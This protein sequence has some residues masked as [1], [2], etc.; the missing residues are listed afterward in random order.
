MLGYGS[1]SV[2]YEFQILWRWR[3][4]GLFRHV[5]ITCCSLIRIM[6]EFQSNFNLK[7]SD[8][9]KMYLLKEDFKSVRLF[10]ILKLHLKNIKGYIISLLACFP[11]L[12]KWRHNILKT[13]LDV[14]LR[15]YMRLKVNICIFPMCV[16][17]LFTL[18][19]QVLP[20]HHFYCYYY[21]WT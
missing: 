14:W 10:Q 18:D 2:N 1:I 20:K 21:Y 19:T 6:W 7:Y 4:S 8:E 9:E 5:S 17:K 13:Y 15:I 11:M 3:M 12:Q 16:P